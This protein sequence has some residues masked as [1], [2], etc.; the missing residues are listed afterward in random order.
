MMVAQIIPFKK[1]K[2]PQYKCSFCGRTAAQS[3]HF[4]V[5]KN[6]SAVCD[7][8]IVHASVRIKET[9]VETEAVL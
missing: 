9:E 5:G 8:C 7:K 6:N 4:W 2:A 3:K 1:D